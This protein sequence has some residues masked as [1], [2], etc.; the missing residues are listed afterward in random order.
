MI[1]VTA[2]WIV[3]LLEF[4]DRSSLPETLRWT[5]RHFGEFAFNSAIVASLLLVFSAIVGRIRPAYWITALV[6]F[7][8]ALI[9]GIKLKML[10][11]PLLPWDF[12]LTS[13]AEDMTGYIKNI[14]NAKL[15]AGVIVFGGVSAFLLYKAPHMPNKLKWK[16]KSI[17]ALVSIALIAVIYSDKPIPLKRAF[18]IA[19]MPWNQGDNVRTNGLA[20]TGLMNIEYLNVDSK[21]SV[22]EQTIAAIVNQQSGSDTPPAGT[23]TAKPNIIVILSE[24]FWDATQIK[25]VTF[26]RDPLPFFHQIQKEYTSGWL[27]SPQYGGGT[28]NVEFEVLTGNSMRF[29]PQGSTAYNQYIDKQVDSL[30]S[31]AARQGYTSTAISPFHAWYFKSNDVYRDFGF[32]KYVS[33]EFFKP[34][35]HGPYIAD[36][37]VANTII[38]ETTQTSGPDF[39]FANTMENHFHY[40]PGKFDKNTIEVTGN[41]TPASE[42]MLET[43]AEGLIGAD[44]M[45]KSLVEHYTASKEPTIIVFFG[46][47]LP[48]LGDD[49]ATFKDTKWISGT[50]DPNFLANMYHTP[51]V[52]WNNYLPKQKDDLAM[53]P[54]FL[55][56]YVLNM[57]QLQGTYYTNFLSE[58]A[59]K[60]PVLPPRD[61]YAGMN[62]DEA[63]T[64]AYE[65]LQN[66]ILFGQQFGYAGFKDKIINPNYI[67][68]LGT[69]KLTSAVMQRTAPDQQA[70]TLLVTGEAIPPLGIV[71][72]NGKALPTESAG[73]GK[74]TAKLQGDS[75]K[76]A[77]LDVQVKVIDSRELAIAE[78]NTIQ[79]TVS[80]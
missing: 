47:H 15:I 74:L 44:N 12:V 42:G 46:D 50:D 43:Y 27:L 34:D 32:G 80:P 2:A 60:I 33:I 66:D 20:L 78:S 62:I 29:L 7:I 72:A 54:S 24:S 48:Y 38:R 21:G 65:Q 76:A 79:A 13:E 36:R 1:A 71:Y 61:Y 3:L 70:A 18:G 45:L 19:A 58:F 25:G 4:V 75:A 68:G 69:M 40:Y 51:V 49:Y 39:V 37:E 8:F 9:S 67:L 35:Y 56:P 17:L 10:G 52:V 55:G 41:M 57:A 16:E 11:V 73:D 31:I 22:D 64:K 77:S 53:S 59:K 6:L 30:A 28:A 63:S 14:A 5:V 23:A 26:S